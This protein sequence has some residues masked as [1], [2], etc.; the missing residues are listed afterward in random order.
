MTVLS[1]VPLPA[2]DLVTFPTSRKGPPKLSGWNEVTRLKRLQQD[3][4]SREYSA[5]ISSQ[6]RLPR[7]ASGHGPLPSP[8]TPLFQFCRTV[9]GTD[10]SA[11]SGQET[12]SASPPPGTIGTSERHSIMALLN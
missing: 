9:I 7:A 11:S 6:V 5:S 1:P 12:S 10:A 8:V 3:P 2:P 4:S